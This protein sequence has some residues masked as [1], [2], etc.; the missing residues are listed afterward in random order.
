MSD[1]QLKDLEN[2]YLKE[3]DGNDEKEDDEVEKEDDEVSNIE[4]K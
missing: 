4:I 2:K 3:D 1:E